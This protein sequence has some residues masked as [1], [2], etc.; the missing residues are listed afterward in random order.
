MADVV[1]PSSP[2]ID[3]PFGWKFFYVTPETLTGVTDVTVVTLPANTVIVDMKII[4]VGAASGVSTTNIDVEVGATGAGDTTVISDAANGGSTL[5]TTSAL[6]LP[7]VANL[8]TINAI[9][10][11]GT[12][13]VVNAEI[14]Y[15]GTETTAP[16][17]A[18]GILCGRNDY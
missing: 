15:G 7:T 2:H 10:L 11:G 12:P 4:T 13:L 14:T 3:R 18:I 17:Y 6:T 16:T 1:N 5:G 9:S 8:L